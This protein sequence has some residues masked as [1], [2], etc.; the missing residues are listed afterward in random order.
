MGSS[1]KVG[2]FVAKLNRADLVI[3]GELLEG[4]SLTSVIDSAFSLDDI[5]DALEHMGSGHPRGK[6]V[7]TM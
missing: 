4:G 3:L 7:V 5:G 1:Q 6:I 2:F